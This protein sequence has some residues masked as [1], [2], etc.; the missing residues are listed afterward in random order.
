MRISK[1]AEEVY[2]MILTILK[3]NIYSKRHFKNINI[4]LFLWIPQYIFYIDC[5]VDLANFHP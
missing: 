2:F 4:S 3:C 5:Q 1:R